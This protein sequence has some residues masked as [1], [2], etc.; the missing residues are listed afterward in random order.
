M[1]KMNLDYDRLIDGYCI[2]HGFGTP[3][4]I[5]LSFNK[6]DKMYTVSSFKHTTLVFTMPFKNSFVAKK[7]FRELM[8]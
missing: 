5:Y 2:Y 1:S 6:S 7:Q 4:L 8:K 3:H